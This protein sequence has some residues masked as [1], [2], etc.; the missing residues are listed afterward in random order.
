MKKLQE[1]AKLIA[2][3]IGTTVTAGV[4]VLAPEALEWLS[5]VGAL[6]TTFAVYQVPNRVAE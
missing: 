1:Y 4:V 3:L 2:A 6:V 5:F